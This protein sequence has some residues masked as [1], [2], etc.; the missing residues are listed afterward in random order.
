MRYQELFDGLV[1]KGDRVLP[2]AFQIAD[3][4][5]ALAGQWNPG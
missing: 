5:D 1:G 2:K 4:I 3:E